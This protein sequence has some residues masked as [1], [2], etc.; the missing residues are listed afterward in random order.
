MVDFEQLHEQADDIRA[1]LVDGGLEELP[2]T[3]LAALFC[4]AR[5]LAT[6]GRHAI[7]A[8]EALERALQREIVRRDA[9]RQ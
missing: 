1:R 7:K 9:D 5:A 6:Q 8:I 2:T 3:D 4:D